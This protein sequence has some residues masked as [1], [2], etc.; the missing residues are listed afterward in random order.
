MTRFVNSVKSAALLG[1]MMGVFLLIGMNFGKGGL[2][3]ALILG[4]FMNFIA[5]FFSDKIALASMQGQ[6][7][8]AQTAPDLVNMVERLARNANLPMPKVY[9]CPQE[10]PNAFATG[11]SPSKAAVA[12][13]RGALRLLSYD[14]LEGVIGHELAHVKNRDTLTSTI[15]ATIAGAITYLTHMLFFMGG[16]NREGVNPIV[17]IAT[18]IL[19]PIAAALI[20]M[21]ISRSREYVADADGAAI[22]GSPQGLINALRKLDA[23]ARG[24][25][26][27]NEMP[28]QN[29]MFIVQPLSGEGLAGLFSTHPPTA[30]RIRRLS[31]I[32]V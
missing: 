6:E 21:A 11:R 7:V 5:F 18:I 12:V 19:A 1:L 15:A 30:E 24:I 20:Q 27:E 32:T 4:G 16:N 17:A 29:H 28:A 22:A 3:I 2:L 13:T 31:E 8:D 10:A 25:P 23:A 14:E 9:I 26:L